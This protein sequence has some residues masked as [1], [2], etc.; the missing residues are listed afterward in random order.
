VLRRILLHPNRG[1]VG[2]VD[3]LLTVCREHHLQVDGHTDRWRVRCCDGDWEDLGDLPLRKSVLRAILARFAA[4]CNEQ[5][6]NSVSP[7]GGQGEFAVGVNPPTIFRIEFTNTL[8]HQGFELTI[9]A[10]EHQAATR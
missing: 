2:L 6:P 10:S 7:Y 4:L 1:V 5:T 3:E 9:A 8:T